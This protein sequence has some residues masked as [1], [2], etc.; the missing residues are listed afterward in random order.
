MDLSQIYK[1][2]ISKGLINP[3]TIQR[4]LMSGVQK[5][6]GVCFEKVSNIP[7]TRGRDG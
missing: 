2:I 5:F 1:I 7:K 6:N 4:S 3:S